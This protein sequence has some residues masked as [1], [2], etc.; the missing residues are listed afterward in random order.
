VQTGPS[1][2]CNVAN[3]TAG[4]ATNCRLVTFGSEV[5]NFITH[6]LTYRYAWRDDLTLT[7]SVFNILDEDPSEARLEISYDPFIGNPLGRTFKIGI[8]KTF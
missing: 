8:K 7:A 3:A 1:T 5:D 4:T 6:D 2:N